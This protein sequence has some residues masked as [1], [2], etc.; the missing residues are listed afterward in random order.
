M[1]AAFYH[2]DLKVLYADD[3]TVT[4]YALKKCRSVH[5]TDVSQILMHETYR[6][7]ITSNKVL[8]SF[9]GVSMGEVRR[10]ERH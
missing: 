9:Y 5:A 8:A 1:R 4:F 3:F 10:I 7:G 6:Y 2:G